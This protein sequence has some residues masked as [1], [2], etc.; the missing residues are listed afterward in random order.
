MATTSTLILSDSRTLAYV[1]YTHPTPSPERPEKLPAIFYF[2]GIPGSRLEAELLAS[3]ARSPSARIIAIDRPGMGL[4]TFD[5]ART[6]LSWPQ[7]VLDLANHLHIEQFYILGASGGGP[8]V[9]A[10]IKALSRERLLGACIVAGFYPVS[11]GTQEMSIS[12]RVLLWVAASNW[13]GSMTGPL[14]DWMFGRV[15]RDYDHPERLADLLSSQLRS[16][17]EAEGKCLDNPWVKDK[18]V[19]AARESFRQGSAGAALDMKLVAGEWGFDLRSLRDSGVRLCLWHGKEDLNIPLSMAERAADLMGVKL[20]V[21]EQEGHLGSSLNHQ[22]QLLKSL[23]SVDGQ[24][25]SET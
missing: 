6:L 9:L 15:A 7:D 3:S 21:F 20:G 25:F 13:V 4:S 17:S 1:D 12:N 10:C 18:V 11:L 19:E 14:M 2:H 23:L 8:Y 24:V 16:R 5:P 22:D